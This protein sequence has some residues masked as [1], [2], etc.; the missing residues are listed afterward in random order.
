MPGRILYVATD[1]DD[2]ERLRGEVGQNSIPLAEDLLNGSPPENCTEVRLIAGPDA[3]KAKVVLER[4]CTKL[5]PISVVFEHEKPSVQLVSMA[6]VPEEPVSWLWPGWLAAGKSTLVVGDPAAGKTTATLDLL[7]RLSRGDTMPDGYKIEKPVSSVFCSFDDAPGDVIRPR[8]RAAN[9]DLSRIY[10]LDGVRTIGGNDKSR[11]FTLEDLDALGEQLIRIEANSEQRVGVLVIDPLSA[12]MGGRESNRIEHAYQVFGAI[13]KFIEPRGIA[14]IVL[15]HAGKGEARKAISV[16]V[17][18]IGNDAAVRFKAFVTR[19]RD[20]ETRRL[21]LNAKCSIGSEPPGLAYSIVDSGIVNTGYAEW[22]QSAYGGTA[23][24]W[25]ESVQDAE[26]GLTTKQTECARF[27]M[28]IATTLTRDA[29]EILEQAQ[30][31]GL[32]ERTLKSTKT[33]MGIASHQSPT[34][35]WVWLFPGET[36]TTC[37]GLKLTSP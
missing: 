36:P 12:F 31:E 23:Q 35:G 8:L 10:W 4:L 7:A 29:G 9:A 28:S 15:H 27:L 33:Q 16:G 14:A 30:S 25:I 6:D 18:S 26:R 5:H 1:R 19:D 34:R 32:C 2:A 17:G 3:R 37:P 21:W 22:E 24:D 11:Q 13:K 20:D